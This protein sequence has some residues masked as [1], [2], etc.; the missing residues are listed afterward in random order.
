MSHYK[1][2][3]QIYLLSLLLP[4]PSQRRRGSK[5][6]FWLKLN[7]KIIRFSV[8]LW[9]LTDRGR[10]RFLQVLIHES[11]LAG[12]FSF[13]IP[14][15]GPDRTTPL[16][17]TTLCWETFYGSDCSWC[18][19]NNLLVFLTVLL[20]LGILTLRPF[21]HCWFIIKPGWL[22]L[23][24]GFFLLPPQPRHFPLEHVSTGG[25]PR[26]SQLT[27]S[28][29]VWRPADWQLSH[30]TAPGTRSLPAARTANSHT[31]GHWSPPS[32]AGRVLSK[33]K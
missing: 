12:K 19:V 22:L 18:W 2:F 10:I 14:N 1:S 16:V 15:P 28:R 9:L 17:T 20:G 31:G 5:K 11:E 25:V 24:L 30:S 26:S 8:R 32:L 3:K 23:S 4:S 21:T 13:L 27:W 7:F 29:L 33:T 6:T